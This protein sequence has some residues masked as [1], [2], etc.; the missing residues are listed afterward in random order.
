MKKWV[1]GVLFSLGLFPD[2]RAWA[3]S[4]E[5]DPKNTITVI[6]G[7]LE[8][9]DQSLSSFSKVRRKDQELDQVFASMG[10]PQSQRTLLLDSQAKTSQVRKAIQAAVQKA[11]QGSTLIFYFAGHGVRREQKIIFATQDIDTSQALETGLTLDELTLLLKPFKGARVLL[12]A[13]CCY[14]GGLIEVAKALNTKNVSV[15]ALTSAEASNAST[16][17]WTFTQNVIDALR[18][19]AHLD[20][21]H[22]GKISLG[23]L[24]KEIRDAMKFREGQRMGWSDPGKNHDL[25]L[26]S[27]KGEAFLEEVKWVRASD[28]QSS[29]LRTARILQAR[30]NRSGEKDL[31][32]AFYD[33]ADESR[34]WVSQKKVKTFDVKTWPIGTHL[35]V[36]W[37]KEVFEA[38]VQSIDGPFMQITY[39][40]W[41]A[42]WD[43]WIT[44][45]RVVGLFQGSPPKNV[46]VEWKGKWYD[47]VVLR[48]EGELFCIH[49]VGFDDSW[50][51][52]V[53]ASRV[54]SE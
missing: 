49:Y 23:D 34:F 22:D 8:W 40:G 11:T 13:D 27:S 33:Y 14:S 51:E 53:E 3:T 10:V 54:K 2:N 37:G 25:V 15:T 45:S 41:S 36:T 39:P 43:E 9:K 4:S 24:A 20:H 31:F 18:G 52:C 6:A 44:S 38:I 28:G 29:G 16:E 48:K 46:K 17:N 35:S 12:M 26:A 30:S 42:I 19:R 7:V 5:L 32:L 21:D 50:D 1:L 47:A